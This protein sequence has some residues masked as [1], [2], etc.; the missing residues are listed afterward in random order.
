MSKY[1]D[2]FVVP[3]PKD[4]IEK[5]RGIAAQAS[6]IWREYGALEYR[7]CVLEDATIEGVMP[8]SQ[9]S[10][11]NEGDTVVFAYIVYNSRA[12]RDEVNAKVMADPRLHEMCPPDGMPFD[13]ARMC[14]SGFETIVE[15]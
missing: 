3:V 12:H 15:A 11:V 8:F 1:I 9:L 4:K 14:Y 10:N 5:Y 7:E 13:C 2:G 6:K